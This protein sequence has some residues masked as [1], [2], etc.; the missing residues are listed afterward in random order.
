MP[1]F[2]LHDIFP[3][4]PGAGW[5]MLGL[6]VM[7]LLWLA[8]KLLVVV[9]LVVTMARGRERIGPLH[10]RAARPAGA[11]LWL[12]SLVTCTLALALLRVEPVSWIGEM[13]LYPGTDTAGNFADDPATV[14]LVGVLL[15]TIH[16]TLAL[17]GA[18]AVRRLLGRRR[19][20]TPGA[21][22]AEPS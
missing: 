12:A 2:L 4:G 16:W 3:R 8:V 20:A 19:S 15:A 11:G 7:L 22:A 10:L 1:P 13:V 5:F 17:T 6:L 21:H 9:G 14:A 18:R